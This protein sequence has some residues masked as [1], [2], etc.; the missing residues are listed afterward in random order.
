LGRAVEI[1]ARERARVRAVFEG[2]SRIY[3]ALRGPG[4]ADPFRDR[5]P[6]SVAE[7]ERIVVLPEDAPGSRL[8][9]S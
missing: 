6:C 8:S 1:L 3:F 4:A 2:V 5:S 7:R 9:E